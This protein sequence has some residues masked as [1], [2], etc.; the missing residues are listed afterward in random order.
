MKNKRI[1]SFLFAVV[2]LVGTSFS[3]FA[4]LPPEST[5]SPLYIEAKNLSSSIAYSG[6][7]AIAKAT[8]STQSSCT[9]KV[10]LTIQ[11]YSSAGWIDYATFPTQTVSTI[12]SIPKSVSNTSY[13]IPDGYYRTSAYIEIYRNGVFVESDTVTCSMKYKG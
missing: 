11:S 6:D 5:V 12:A 7:S 13:N 9:V 2:V 1:L 3:A 8:I 10:T 4:A